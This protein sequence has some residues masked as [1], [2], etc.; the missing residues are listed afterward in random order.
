MGKFRVYAEEV[1]S[2]RSEYFPNV[3]N[4]LQRLGAWALA[5]VIALPENNSWKA[6]PMVDSPEICWNGPDLDSA[7]LEQEIDTISDMIARHK[8]A[9]YIVIEGAERSWDIT[10]MSYVEASKTVDEIQNAFDM[11]IDEIDRGVMS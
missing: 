4:P 1:K 10:D 8:K 7:V 3:H 9:G 6:F 5:A 2:I 11:A